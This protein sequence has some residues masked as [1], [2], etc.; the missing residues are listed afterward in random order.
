[1]ASFTVR[2]TDANGATAT[3]ALTLAA[4]AALAIT[5]TSPLLQATVSNAYN[6]TITVANGTAPL[7]WTITDGTLPTG[8]SLNAA[9][10]AITGS[11]KAADNKT[12]MVK[13]TDANGTSDSR[14]FTLVVKPAPTITSQSPLADGFLGI[15]YSQTL[16]ASGGVPPLTWS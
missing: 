7:T 14:E 8:L 9:N 15:S 5:A 10:G 2:V 4:N 3:K 1:S 11:A 6:Q 13:V 16:A 12:F